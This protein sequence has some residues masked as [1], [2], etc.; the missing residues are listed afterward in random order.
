MYQYKIKKNLL[1]NDYNKL[2]NI[3]DDL[4]DGEYSIDSYGYDEDDF[5]YITFI[6]ENFIFRIELWEDDKDN[7]LYLYHKNNHNEDDI[8]NNANYIINLHNVMNDNTITDNNTI[9]NKKII[10]LLKSFKFLIIK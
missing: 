5:L 7:I 2:Y 3:L 10:N 8:I 6:Y 1:L 4:L 9:N